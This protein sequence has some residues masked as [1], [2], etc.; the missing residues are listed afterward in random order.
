LDSIGLAGFSHD[1][2]A[3]AN[4]RGEVVQA[5]ESLAEDSVNIFDGLAILLGSVFPFLTNL[6]TPR[7]KAIARLNT[8]CGVLAKD[9]LERSRQEIAGEKGDRS[10]MGLLIK[11]EST[12][13]AMDSAALQEELVAQMKT[14]MVAGY[15]TTSSSL[16]WTLIE[17]CRRLDIQQEL[18]DEL[19]KAFP[20]SDPTHE[21]INNQTTLPLLDAV[22]HEVLRLHPAVVETPR[23]AIKDDIIPLSAPITLPDGSSTDR[24]FIAKGQTVTVPLNAV[25]RA[26][27]FWGE[28]AKEFRPSRWLASDLG[29]A[30]ELSTYR[31]L[32]TFIDGPK[33]CLGKSF[34]VLEMKAVLAV[35]FRKYAFEL[36]QGPETPIG[37][38]VSIVLRPK[39]EGEKGARVPLR[40]RRLE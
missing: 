18:R 24:I 36:L 19:M 33:T 20:S 1:F 16:T 2:Q 29:K 12:G 11:A 6:P 25:N 13:G 28:D 14:L 40:V 23:T 3:L 4:G 10:V 38:S 30:Q 7:H 26:R 17:L 22:V 39:V 37:K 9:L 27:N 31:H 15:E 35:L 8:A 32:M 5:F 21:D 34:A